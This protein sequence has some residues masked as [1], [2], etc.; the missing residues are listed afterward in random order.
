MADVSSINKNNNSSISKD[1]FNTKSS[2]NYDPNFIGPIKPLTPEEQVK[3]I[4]RLNL[5]SEES[6]EL[7]EVINLNLMDTYGATNIDEL[8]EGLMKNLTDEQLKQKNQIDTT[9]TTISSLEALATQ[10][11]TE[12]QKELEGL[13]KE[14]K[15][16]LDE[17]DKIINR[18]KML[19]PSMSDEAIKM[20]LNDN[21]KVLEARKLKEKIDALKT[22]IGIQETYIS[23]LKR[24]EQEL[25]YS[26]L[27]LTD[28]YQNFNI[29]E[30]EIYKIYKERKENGEDITYIL[31]YEEQQKIPGHEENPLE[32]GAQKKINVDKEHM[33]EEQKKMLSFILYYAGPEAGEKYYKSIE[34][35]I[36]KK[37]GQELAQKRIE[38]LDVND[39]KKIE[40]TLKNFGIITTTGLEDGLSSFFEGINNILFA[41]GKISAEDYE[42]LYYL[43]YLEEHSDYFDET[44]SIS[45]SIG[46][47]IPSI[48]ASTIISIIGG[49]E[50]APIVASS[51][52]GASAGGN[53][54]E[55]ALQMGA[56]QLTSTIY[57]TLIGLS[58]G[59][60][61]EKLGN[62]PGISEA[63]QLSLMG[64]IKEGTEEYVQE[65]V[66]GFC[67]SLLLGQKFDI[68]QI[69]KNARKAFILGCIT[70][71]IMNGATQT[72]K[73][74]IGGLDYEV[75]KNVIEEYL[76]NHT[77]LTTEDIVNIFKNN[78]L[79]LFNKPGTIQ[80]ESETDVAKFFG[81]EKQYVYQ[82]LKEIRKD[83]TNESFNKEFDE[84]L[85]DKRTEYLPGLEGSR[86]TAFYDIDAMKALMDKYDFWT[87]EDKIALQ[88]IEYL[89]ANKESLTEEEIQT[90]FLFTEWVGPALAAYNRKTTTIYGSQKIDGANAK[91][92]QEYLDASISRMNLFFGTDYKQ[93]DIEHFN[94]IIDGII[95]KSVIEHDVTVYRGINGIYN[96]NKYINVQDLKP[97]TVFSDDAHVSTSVIDTTQTTSHLYKLEIEVPAGTHGAYIESNTGVGDYAQQE[98]LLGRNVQFE[99]TGEP[100][101][102]PTTGQITIPVK[103]VN[104]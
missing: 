47:M 72:I 99:V 49:P 58:E 102:D 91:E 32:I 60:L 53:A 17:I 28:E 7:P 103:I 97:G 33:S 74:T 16:K 54:K 75:S 95:E 64:I 85:K 19:M 59:F 65:Y 98:L 90:I 44:Y 1:I 57:G 41:E 24:T 56:D 39:E 5:E 31:S 11:V 51:M 69:D 104:E 86:S 3:E 81:D 36:N 8:Y 25:I 67:Q 29:E 50:L 94:Q 48:T 45:N 37:V 27:M 71:G 76:N 2:V 82:R 84:L 12:K 96:D 35:E 55:Q 101:K 73:M 42:K 43:Q 66:E 13:E 22:D 62:I 15:N 100:R 21:E 52:M 83:S 88:A 63:A 18:T 93:C 89:N 4:Q 23:Q 34:D 70:S 30:N 80:F 87:H 79:N 38:K 46:N 77:E 6:Q 10:D 9:I 26:Q 68:E 20:S 40:A 14:Y 78:N 92:M 61:G